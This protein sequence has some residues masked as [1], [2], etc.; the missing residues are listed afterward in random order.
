MKTTALRKSEEKSHFWY[1]VTVHTSARKVHITIFSF[2][3]SS[4]LAEFTIIT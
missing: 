4:F 3:S 2:N 1:M